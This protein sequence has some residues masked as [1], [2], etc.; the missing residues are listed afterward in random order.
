MEYGLQQRQPL[1][2]LAAWLWESL[3]GQGERAMRAMNIPFALVMVWY[4]R[5]I[6]SSRGKTPWYAI[7]LLIQPVV[8]WYMNAVDPALMTGAAAAAFFYYALYAPDK[9]KTASLVKMHLAFALGVAANTVFVFVYP[10]FLAEV[11]FRRREESPEKAK[12]SLCLVST[13]YLALAACVMSFGVAAGEG[14]AGW[15]FLGIGHLA[16]VV[17]LFMGLGGLSYS[18]NELKIQDWGALDLF[19]ILAAVTLVVAIVLVAVALRRRKRFG[20][21]LRPNLVLMIGCGVYLVL[22]WAA[23]MVWKFSFTERNLFPLVVLL[24]LLEADL[25]DI[26]QL[27]RAHRALQMAIIVLVGLQLVSC[28][29]LRFDERY[30]KE[31]YRSVSRYLREAQQDSDVTILTSGYHLAY[32][33]YGVATNHNCGF[34]IAPTDVITKQVSGFDPEQLEEAV[35]K[36]DKPVVLVL[37]QNELPLESFNWEGSESSIEIG[38]ANGFRIFWIE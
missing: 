32:R 17:Y 24:A 31:D 21:L 19:G 26:L 1:F 29:R 35:E 6:L 14:A 11:Y 20:Q 8:A 16:A 18:R 5:K 9:E 3:L 13:G 22:V 37:S 10:V 34:N 36:A 30:G 23:A 15:D 33:F 25:L 7:L 38:N 4:T 2:M 12:K 28:G 27:N